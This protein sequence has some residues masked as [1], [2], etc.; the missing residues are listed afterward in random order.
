ME[1]SALIQALPAV[2]MMSFREKDKKS[3]GLMLPLDVTSLWSVPSVVR[4]LSLLD[5]HDLEHLEDH[6]RALFIWAYLVFPH[7]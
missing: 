5:S 7:D 4:P 2:P 1:S 3:Q 6:R